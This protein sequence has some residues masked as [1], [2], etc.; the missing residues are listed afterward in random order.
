MLA[1]EDA[2][3]EF[4]APLREVLVLLLASSKEEDARLGMLLCQLAN[5]LVHQW[6]GVDLPLV[7]SKGR[8]AN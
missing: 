4:L 5:D 8:N 3:G 1:D 7:G 2:G 6:G